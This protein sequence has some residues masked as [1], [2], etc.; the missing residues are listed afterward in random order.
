M[1]NNLRLIYISV[2]TAISLSFFLL[3]S[4]LPLPF[5]A[6]GAKLGLANIVTVFAL[7]FLPKLKDVFILVLLRTALAAFFGG[8]LTIFFYSIAGGLLSLAAMALLKF[9]GKFSLI[10]VSMG[11]GFFHNFGQL[12]VAY[13]L[14]GSAGIWLYFPL[15]GSVGIFTGFIIGLITKYTL[16][17]IRPAINKMQTK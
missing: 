9:S 15:L 8:G 14:V 17:K 13:F 1:K 16:K 4:L 10:G 3:E 12:I 11:G 7:F 5:L 6:P 2:L